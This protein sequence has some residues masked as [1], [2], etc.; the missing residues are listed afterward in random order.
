MY[1]G[2]DTGCYQRRP[3]IVVHCFPEVGF[4]VD[5]SVLVDHSHADMPVK[6]GD[7]GGGR[8]Q[9]FGEVE[10]AARL[11][12]VEQSYGL[13][14]VRVNASVHAGKFS[15][16]LPSQGPLRRRFLSGAESEI[17]AH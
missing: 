3:A 5:A 1:E 15:S 8:Y 7:L 2:V 4:Q 10:C 14:E 16:G 6:A 11:A 17:E 12:F 13:L 9:A